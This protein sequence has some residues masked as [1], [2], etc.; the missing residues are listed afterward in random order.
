MINIISSSV[1]PRTEKYP[2][3][4]LP[5]KNAAR[6]QSKYSPLNKPLA[7]FLILPISKTYTRTLS[8]DYFDD[9]TSKE[10]SHYLR[11]AKQKQTTKTTQTPP[12][13][14]ET[15]NKPLEQILQI[16]FN[17][18][19][20]PDTSKPEIV[21]NAKQQ[22]SP[23]NM[24]L[25]SHTQYNISPIEKKPPCNHNICDSACLQSAS[26][27]RNEPPHCTRNIIFSFNLNY[28][29]VFPSENTPNRCNTETMPPLEKI[30]PKLGHNEHQ[31]FALYP[32]KNTHTPC[33]LN[34]VTT[35]LK[36]TFIHCPLT[37]L[38]HN[39]CL[40]KLPKT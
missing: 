39:R 7:K 40:R 29:L 28:A 10:N 18:L 4:P 34:S 6:P 15:R 23:K 30:N 24:L 14:T 38:A 19:T 12:S 8:N 33:L 17:H 11:N 25:V 36:R 21:R 9:L 26:S 5:K 3:R 13:R 27:L 1:F 37:N 22:N 32:T 2:L 16:T 20:I 35:K 31:S